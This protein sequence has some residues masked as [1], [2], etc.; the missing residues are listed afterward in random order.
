[1]APE[2]GV[3]DANNSDGDGPDDDDDAAEDS[4]RSSG[5]ASEHE[6]ADTDDVDVVVQ[7]VVEPIIEDGFEIALREA[8]LV[9]RHHEVYDRPTD[10][11]LGKVQVLSGA[12]LS[13]KACCSCD[14]SHL[15]T[16]KR[17]K[18]CFLLIKAESRF[19]EKY[20]RCLEW[21][22]LGLERSRSEH[23]QASIDARAF[24]AR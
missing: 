1:M 17:Q 2:G 13:L 24:F 7:A 5:D 10:S 8:G 11:L 3:G 18:Q 21:L 6:T 15:P 19:W 9:E 16:D 20:R 23:D 4:A 22:K 14:V 12:S